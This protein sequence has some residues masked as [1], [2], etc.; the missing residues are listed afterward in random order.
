V[1]L[2]LVGSEMCIRDR[3]MKGSEDDLNLRGAFLHMAADALVS[4]G[5]AGAGALYLHFGWP[6][7]DPLVSLLIALVIVLGTW[8]LL[9]QS[10][11]LSFDGVPEGIDV[12][13]IHDWLAT[14]PGVREVHD[15]H[16]WAL[17]TSDTALTVHL[18]MPGG[19][20]GD[21]FLKQLAEELRHHHRIGHPTIQIELEGLADSCNPPL[22]PARS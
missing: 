22:R 15:L 8:G 12:Q 17:G 4:L 3:F 7:L 1:P 13:R 16:V 11:H 9:R 21:A 2:R 18:V 6:W 20:P 10:L 5:V 14:R 19:H